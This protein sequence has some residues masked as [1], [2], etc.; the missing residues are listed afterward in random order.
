MEN[1]NPNDED[2]DEAMSGVLCR[3]GTYSTIRRAIHKAAKEVKA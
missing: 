1:P 3:C 2:I